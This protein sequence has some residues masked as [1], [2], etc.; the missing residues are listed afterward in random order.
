MGE[1][2]DLVMEKVKRLEEQRRADEEVLEDLRTYLDDLDARGKGI[3]FEFKDNTGIVS[4]E[5]TKV[6]DAW[7]SD[8]KISLTSA[9]AETETFK[10]ERE[11]RDRMATLVAIAIMKAQDA[12]REREDEDN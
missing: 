1:W 8:G 9:G 3:S 4:Y 11:A 10:K 6:F 7:V 12:K 2:L 5:G